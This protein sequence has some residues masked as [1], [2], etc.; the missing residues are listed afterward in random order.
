MNATSSFTSHALLGGAP[1]MVD[2]QTL[3]SGTVGNDVAEPQS[4][5]S[6]STCETYHRS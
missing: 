5:F 2:N 1:E 6:A 4:L 3:S